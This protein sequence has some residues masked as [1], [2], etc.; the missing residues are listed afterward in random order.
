M[1]PPTSPRPHRITS[2]R[3]Y[4]LS[5]STQGPDNGV[6][7]RRL[8]AIESGIKLSG[9]LRLKQPTRLVFHDEPP[10]HRSSRQPGTEC[11]TA[12]DLLLPFPL[13]CTPTAPHLAQ[14]SAFSSRVSRREY[15]SHDCSTRHPSSAT[16]SNFFPRHQQSACRPADLPPLLVARLEPTPRRRLF[17]LTYLS[18]LRPPRS[19]RALRRMH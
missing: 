9:V 14:H 12:P 19:V 11:C 8:C 15:A 10:R 5:Q 2:T 18:R 1:S 7:E 17:T 13:G 6:C 16:P 4:T 3:L